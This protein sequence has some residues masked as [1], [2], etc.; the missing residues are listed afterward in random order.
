MP[1][2]SPTPGEDHRPYWGTVL[3]VNHKFWSGH[4]PGDRWN[5]KCGLHATDSKPTGVPAGNPVQPAPGL[6]SDPAKTGQMFSQSHPYVPV[7]CASCR[8]PGDK[9]LGN[10]AGASG[11]KRCYGCSRTALAVARQATVKMTAMAKDLVYSLPYRQQFRSVYEDGG[12]HV[13]QHLFAKPNKND[14]NDDHND[15]LEIAKAFVRT[16]RSNV[17]IN[18][19]IPMVSKAGRKR[20]F[21]GIKSGANPD[22]TTVFGYV[23]VKLPQK[24]NNSV[25]NINKAS[26]QESIALLSTSRMKVKPTDKQLSEII[27]NVWKS[28]IY[29]KDILFVHH[30]GNIINYKRP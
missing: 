14:P 9:I 17:Y 27:K 29:D 30:N 20:I 25:T 10:L 21:K 22:L 16:F 12:K 11:P 28:K 6:D 3:P 15:K 8:L 23:D 13:L 18:P 2:T 24:Y 19:T 7:N 1:T 5:C 26:G 4:K